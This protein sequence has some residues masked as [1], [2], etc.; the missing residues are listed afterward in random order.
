MGAVLAGDEPAL[1]RRVAVKLLSPELADDRSAVERFLREAQL[2]ATVAHPHVVPIYRVGRTAD[3]EVP[4]FVMRLVPGRALDVAYPDGTAA[5]IPDA[6]RIGGQVASALAAAHALGVVHRD[7]KPANILLEEASGRAL[8]AD[9]GISASLTAHAR[10]E[11][12]TELGQTLGTPR[13]MSPEAAAG[14]DVGPPADVY[15]LGC[16]LRELLSGRPVFEAAGA[17]AMV[18]AHVRD[19]PP[20]IATL[21]PDLESPVAAM[22]DR[23]LAKEPTARPTAV[24]VAHL[25]VEE[26]LPFAWPPPGL[27]AAQGA[28][29]RMGW[30]L[31]AATAILGAPLCIALGLGLDAAAVN[32][33]VG[34]FATITLAAL[35]LVLV[36][37]TM[38]SLGFL[39][40]WL[41]RVAGL[42][43][44]WTIAADLLADPGD[45][46][47]LIAGRRRFA[48]I[49]E[50]RRR[51]LRWIR[52]LRTVLLLLPAPGLGA[53]LA[54]ATFTGRVFGWS[55]SVLV[56]GAVG[57]L[58]G[59]LLGV[60]I[61]DATV[62]GAG[63]AARRPDGALSLPKPAHPAAALRR[64]EL[65]RW[66]SAAGV[67]GGT[68]GAWWRRAG[69][70][71]VEVGLSAT[72]LLTVALLLYLVIQG[73]LLAVSGAT[74][75]GPVVRRLAF[76]RSWPSVPPSLRPPADSSLD[77]LS[78]G[79]IAAHLFRPALPSR[80][81][82]L[83]GDAHPLPPFAGIRDTADAF[84]GAMLDLDRWQRV[85]AIAATHALSPAQRLHLADLARRPALDD[86]RRL[87]SAPALDLHGALQAGPADL[88]SLLVAW[89][90]ERVIPFADAVLA[91]GAIALADGHPERAAAAVRVVLGVAERLRADGRTTGDYE[92]A[93]NLLRLGAGA[94]PVLAAAGAL[95]V[96]DA[97]SLRLP[98]ASASGALGPSADRWR[99]AAAVAWM[100]G[101]AADT[102][103]AMAL[104]L[105]AVDQV[106]RQRCAGPLSGLFAQPVDS[107][108]LALERGVRR[109]SDR[110]L[111]AQ[112]REGALAR[113]ASRRVQG[114]GAYR[115]GTEI[116]RL[117]AAVASIVR[118][119][120]PQAAR[121][122]SAIAAPP[123]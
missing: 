116:P 13:Y 121:C 28:A 31:T 86:F 84:A 103:A 16:V 54:V 5:S 6:L 87:A 120:L 4:F 107:A 96:A 112:A 7:V 14:D 117:M 35:M 23:M 17:A 32:S 69:L 39:T 59:C 15:S 91:D 102:T 92:A 56:V 34:I 118:T 42:G 62:E 76:D 21:R 60:V 70:A 65:A 89:R 66:M 53:F 113:D 106:R 100:N 81:A 33:A 45:T 98:V 71:T 77:S 37:A 109:A 80:A 78:A 52:M 75:E 111:V 57:L 101:L 94:V 38:M 27:E 25:L 68:H 64:D 72:G 115:E 20:P 18:A 29:L 47:A 9:F 108:G 41:R 48:S 85:F 10:N 122:W 36:V 50:A 44:P 83:P 1:A 88:P 40:T 82:A 119:V 63:A 58:A 30:G 61:L 73:V 114:G 12:F 49:A 95:P 99:P 43:L 74:Q 46:G 93:T 2:A 105:A 8:I 22:L 24:D 19:T 11:R 104:R 55:A 90:P 26:S 110:R 79:M 123:F 3:G 51:R 67:A 97:L